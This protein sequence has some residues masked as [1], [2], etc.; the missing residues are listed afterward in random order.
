MDLSSGIASEGWMI[1][2]GGLGDA[3]AR[4][5]T[6]RSAFAE[7]SEVVRALDESPEAAS[8]RIQGAILRY[9]GAVAAGMVMFLPGGYDE[10]R[11]CPK[12][13]GF[14]DVDTPV[15]RTLEELFVETT[16][17]ELDS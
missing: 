11:D 10:A 1:G 13:P 17:R 6:S 15:R 12:I 3:G 2:E 5:G 9:L 8:A 4:S 16:N 7:L 14:P